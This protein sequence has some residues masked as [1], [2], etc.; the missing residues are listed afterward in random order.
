[1]LVAD[2]AGQLDLA[3]LAGVEEGHGLAHA[4]AGA[5]L[6]PGLANAAGLAGRL[7]DPAAL[8]HVVT[9]RLLDVD[10]LAGLEGP[11]GRQGVPVVRSGD[12]DDVDGLVVHDLAQV[13]DELGGLSLGFFGG[14]HGAADDIA[15]RV[16][17]RGD[18]AVIPSGKSADVALA[19]P[20]HA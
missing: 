8:A 3:E 4:R 14:F 18:H 13:L 16:A 9:D 7:D 19:P 11:D 20:V 6:G 15:V 1:E 12:R 10:V 5:A 17:D 2:A